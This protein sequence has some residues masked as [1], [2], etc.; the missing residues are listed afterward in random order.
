[1]ALFDVVQPIVPT[2]TEKKKK[3]GLGGLC[4]VLLYCFS[5]TQR[6]TTHMQQKLTLSAQYRHTVDMET[7]VIKTKNLQQL[8]KRKGGNQTDKEL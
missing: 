2:A 3:A 1:M 6:C 7:T 5:A 4:R 8:S